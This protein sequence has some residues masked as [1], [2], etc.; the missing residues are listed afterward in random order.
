M[1]ESFPP[2]HEY[3]ESKSDLLFYKRKPIFSH[4]EL[5]HNNCRGSN[6]VRKLKGDEM[7]PEVDLSLSLSLSSGEG[8]RRWAPGRR[9]E[10][11]GASESCDSD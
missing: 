4:A 6:M 10:I 7:C 11:V 8:E 1:S 2:S 5:R 3:A 9:A